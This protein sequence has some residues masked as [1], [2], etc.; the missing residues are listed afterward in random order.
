VEIQLFV[1]AN[2]R[3]E[4]KGVEYKYQKKVVAAIVRTDY[5]GETA[6][7]YFDNSG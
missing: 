5:S 1:L 6:G 4:A 7:G 2:K 3:A